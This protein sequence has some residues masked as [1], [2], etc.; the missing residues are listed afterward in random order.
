MIDLP[1]RNRTLSYWRCGGYGVR[2][3][4]IDGYAPN[5][6][7]R[8]GV[9]H[10]ADYQ[11]PFWEL[12]GEEALRVVA[13]WKEGG[14]HVDSTGVDGYAPGLATN[15]PLGAMDIGDITAM[16]G[17]PSTYVPGQ[18]VTLRATL[19]YAHDV[20]GLLWRPQLP[21]GWTILSVQANGGTP[22]V[23]NN[24]IL[25]TGKLPA[26]L[27]EITYVCGVPE[28]A[29]GDVL[30]Q[31][32]VRIMRPGTANPQSLF[33]LMAPNLLQLD[34]DG[35][36]LPDWVETDTGIFINRTNT[37]T[38]PNNP[39]TD[40]DGVWDGEEV[41]AGTNPNQNGECFRVLSLAPM[42]GS[43]ILAAGSPYEIRWA[44]VDGKRYSIFRSTNLLQGFQVIRSNLL[45]TPP[46]NTFIDSLPPDR[47]GAYSIGVE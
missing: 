29:Q 38:D 11:E 19:G 36:R 22:E 33:G 34:S 26:S 24:E 23:V 2:P 39:D 44:S 20:L 4:T 9:R 21:A 31:T 37:G 40:G 15:G 42:T 43:S 10:K 32:D 7:S 1:E 27:L 3:G 17:A 13:Y 28:D 47:F 16:A 25:F 41:P 8:N 6:T 35:D 5:E 46:A 30:V 12:D 45:A 14:Y 18:S